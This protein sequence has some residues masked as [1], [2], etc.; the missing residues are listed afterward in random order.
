MVSNAVGYNTVTIDKQYQLIAVNFQGTTGGSLDIQAAFPV[1]AGM[2]SGNSLGNADQI[3][4]MDSNGDYI[5]YYLSNGYNGKA[6]TPATANKWVKN[7]AKTTPS[8]DTVATGTAFWYISKNGATTPYDI[9]VAGSVLMS[10]NEST[11]LSQTYSL[12]GSPY[13]VEIP[14]NDC[15]VAVN[16]TSGNSLGNADQIQIMDSNG[17]YIAY[18]LSNGYNGKAATP[19]TANKWVKNTAKTAPTT[20]TFPVGKGAWFV[21]KSAST[22]L[23]FI[24][25]AAPAQD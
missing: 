14:F 24:N 5:A 18:Y 23:K 15:I 10:S 8:S 19:A 1:S 11:D 13:P 12:V 2:T 21:R 20:D 22:E 9:T 25:P 17:D 7:T 4:I 6:S 16:G 3:Q